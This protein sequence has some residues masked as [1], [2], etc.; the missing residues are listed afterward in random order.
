MHILQQSLK[1]KSLTID[2]WGA[3]EGAAKRG[4]LG[5]AEEERGGKWIE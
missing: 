2:D 4:R 3:M 5:R 1:K